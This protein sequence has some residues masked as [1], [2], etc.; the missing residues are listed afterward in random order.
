[1]TPPLPLWFTA[2]WQ[3]HIIRARDAYESDPA[4]NLSGDP[5]MP[6]ATDWFLAE[7]GEN[8]YYPYEEPNAEEDAIITAW[9][10]DLLDEMDLSDEDRVP[11]GD[12]TSGYEP[13]HAN[14]P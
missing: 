2:E 14:M 4:I 10:A 8:N 3:A 6:K 11:A 1:M 5:I 12:G 9:I 13:G 7:V